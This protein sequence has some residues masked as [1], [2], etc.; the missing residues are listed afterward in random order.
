MKRTTLFLPD[1]YV[2]KLHAFCRATGLTFSEVIRRAVDVYLAQ[3]VPKVTNPARA[4]TEKRR[5]K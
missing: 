2:E 5:T 3:E 4:I 1:H